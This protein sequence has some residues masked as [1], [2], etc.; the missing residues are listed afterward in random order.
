MPVIE[1]IQLFNA[2]LQLHGFGKRELLDDGHIHH[3]DR[4]TALLASVTRPMMEPR[5]SC[6]ATARGRVNKTMATKLKILSAT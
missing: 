6:A 3:V 2:Q 1:R 5:V 4:L